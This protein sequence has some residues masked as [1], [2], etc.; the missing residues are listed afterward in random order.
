MHA[1]KQHPPFKQAG[2]TTIFLFGYQSCTWKRFGPFCRINPCSGCNSGIN[3]VVVLEYTFS[4]TLF[5]SRTNSLGSENLAKATYTALLWFKTTTVKVAL[6]FF[7]WYALFPSR[8]TTLFQRQ[9]DVVRRL[10]TSYQRWN[11]VMCPQRK[12]ICVTCFCWVHLLH[13]YC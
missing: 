9:H 12:W 8:H 6:L 2:T 5:K 11:D 1:E 7:A 10:T 13:K 3:L 4:S